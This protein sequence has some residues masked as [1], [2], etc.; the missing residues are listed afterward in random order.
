MKEARLSKKPD[1]PERWEQ[2][3]NGEVLRSL[4]EESLVESSRMLF[5]YHLVKLGNLSAQIQLPAC[6]IKHVVCQTELPCEK[7]SLQSLSRELPFKENS[8]DAFL[9]A[10]ELDFAQDPHQ[11]LREVDRTITPNGHVV[12]VGFNPFSLA[13]LFKY[14]PVNRKNVLHHA[15]FFSCSRIRDWLHLLGFEVTEL[16]HHLFSPLF[17]ER[18]LKPDSKWHKL[19][20]QYLPYCSSMYVIIAKKRVL[21]LSLIKPVWKPKP[22]FSPVSASMREHT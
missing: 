7:A 10:H 20:V 9:L 5:G 1:Y 22:R 11:I 8:V 16:Q 14:L 19:G 21:P 12:I 2:L 3:P 17:F 18:R 15:R 13:G 6:P 4:V